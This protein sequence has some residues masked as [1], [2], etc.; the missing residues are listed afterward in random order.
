MRHFGYNTY[1]NWDRAQKQAENKAEQKEKA[2]AERREKAEETVLGF[3]DNSLSEEASE[4]LEPIFK[5]HPAAWD[6]YV[7]AL[8]KI[9]MISL[10]DKSIGR[11]A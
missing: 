9:V 6:I 10:K 2:E 4:I 3:I 11:A 7:E 8:D 1:A 5:E